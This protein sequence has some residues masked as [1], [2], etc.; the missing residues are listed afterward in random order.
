[1]I[2]IID[3][4]GSLKLERKDK[5]QSQRCPYVSLHGKE[6]LQQYCGDWC[7]H[8]GEPEYL[9]ILSTKPTIKLS[10]CNG[11]E[12]ISRSINYESVDQRCY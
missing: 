11:T 9:D 12:F 1:M 5:L 2:F 8:F 10:I 7:P 3:K 4:H 6:S